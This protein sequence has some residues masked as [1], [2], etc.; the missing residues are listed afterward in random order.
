MPSSGYFFTY[1]FSSNRVPTSQSPNF[2][3]AGTQ[4]KSGDE[5]RGATT[6]QEVPSTLQ[7]LLYRGHPS[8]DLTQPSRLV[9]QCNR[10]CGDKKVTCT[11]LM[12]L[13]LGW[14]SPEAEKAAIS[15]VTENSHCERGGNRACMPSLTIYYES[16]NT[17]CTL[18][19]L[20]KEN[21]F[22]TDT[23]S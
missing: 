5:L 14:Y 18:S 19:T 22:L 23:R 2:D 13:G 9:C 16:I 20:C 8:A 6:T 7:H 3:S 21:F 12:F 1:K 17:E 11:T 15:L 4:F 10:S